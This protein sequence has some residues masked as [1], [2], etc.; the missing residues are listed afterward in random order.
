M[1]NQALPP[2]YL[3]AVGALFIAGLVVF[4][5]GGGHNFRN[6]RVARG[7]SSVGK[8]CCRARGVRSFLW[9]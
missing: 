8:S 4:I 6:A 5:V 9:E 2:E 1:H 3:R 7:S